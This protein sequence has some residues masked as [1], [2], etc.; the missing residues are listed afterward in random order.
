MR[1]SRTEIESRRRRLPEWMRKRVSDTEDVVA[2]KKVLRKR[3]L[4]TVC[5]SAGCPNVS[6]C[7][8]KPTATF[9]ILGDV[10]T[11]NCRFCGIAK[12]KPQPVDTD[13]P[14]R[15]AETASAMGLRHVVITSVTRDDLND[16]RSSQFAETVRQIRSQL[17][18]ATVEALIPDFLGHKKNLETVLCSRPDILNHNVET[19]PALYERI[20]P[21]ANFQR[22]LDVLSHA[23]V[24]APGMITKSG[25]MVGLGESREELLFVFHALA[26]I[27]CDA[28][29]IGQYLPPARTSAP[30][31][32]F[33]HPDEF[34]A[35]RT[36]AL[37]AGIPWVYAGP[38]IRSSYNA[39]ALMEECR[40]V[41]A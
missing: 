37:A 21:E 30:V 41:T 1:I 27:G 26:E 34:E 13:E 3:Q 19:V 18:E 39:G 20:R 11:R 38:F 4:H 29:T 35:L 10:C 6:E 5:Q 8:K 9:M 24:H 14:A 28:L 31:V 17:P 15:I 16:G 2:L 25:L 7:F 40:G 12:G 33:I 23:K 36:E 32:E 22:S